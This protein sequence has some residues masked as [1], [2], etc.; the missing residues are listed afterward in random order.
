[1]LFVAVTLETFRRA[2]FFFAGPRGGV[3]GRP[4][5]RPPYWYLAFF[6]D[7]FNI[8]NEKNKDKIDYRQSTKIFK[9]IVDIIYIM[10][11]VI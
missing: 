4:E 10:F 6:S 8:Y 11:K 1:M 3:T 7:G 2:H 5:F 9:Y